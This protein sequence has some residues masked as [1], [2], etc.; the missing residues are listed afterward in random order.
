MGNEIKQSRDHQTRLFFISMDQR[1][2]DWFFYNVLQNTQV[3]KYFI[4][5]VNMRR[6]SDGYVHRKHLI[7]YLPSQPQEPEEDIY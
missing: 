1:S 2:R 6:A 7:Y 3:G 4:A 5:I